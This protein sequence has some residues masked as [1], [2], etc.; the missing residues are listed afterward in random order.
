VGKIKQSILIVED[1]VDV[2]EMLDAYFRVHDYEVITVHWGEDALEACWKKKP[3]LIILDIRL[4]DIDGFDIARQLR[5]SR[6][7][8]NIPIIFLTEKRGRPD[9]LEGLSLGADDYITKPFDIQ[10]LRLRVRNSLKRTR[11]GSK[12]NPITGFSDGEF[13]DEKLSECIGDDDSGFILICLENMDLFRDHYGFVSSDD[14]LRAISLMITNAV[15]DTGRPSDF[16]GHVGPYEFVIVSLKSSIIN[17]YERIKKRLDSSLDFFYP[18]EDLVEKVIRPED[19]L[20][21][22]IQI[23]EYKE[24]SYKNLTQLKQALEEIIRS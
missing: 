10:E 19:Q 21:L 6:R 24:G 1:D 9:I 22:K 18:L 7:T 11:Q 16:I 2:A 17:I 15:R 20:A 3:D 5:N 13:V 4:P 23:L 8:E 14:V 12:I